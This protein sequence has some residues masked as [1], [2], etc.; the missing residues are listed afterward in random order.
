MTVA[1]L[2]SVSASADDIEVFTAGVHAN[3]RPNIM[4]VL[5]FSGSMNEGV[6]SSTKSR[7]EILESALTQVIDLNRDRINAGVSSFRWASTGIQWPV[8]DPNEYANAYDPAIPESDSLRVKDIISNIVEHQNPGSSTNTVSALVEAAAYFRGDAVAHGGINPDDT[9]LFKPHHWNTTLERYAGG[10]DFAANPITYTP[11]NAY[12]SGLAGTGKGYCRDYSGTG[13]TNHCAG[14]APLTCTTVPPRSGT[15]SE[16][17]NPW[18][19]DGYENC[20][21]PHPDTWQGATYNSPIENECQANF[22]VLISDGQPTS[23]WSYPGLESVLGHST[24]SCEDLSSS[25]F[26]DSGT[27][28]GNCGPE[29]VGQLHNNNQ[30]SGV[31]NSNV[32]TYTI[33]FNIDGDGSRYLDRLAEAGGGDFFNAQTP[34]DLGDA[35]DKSLNEILGGSANFAELS[36]DIDKAT[37]SNDNRVFFPLFEPSLRP[38]WEGNLKGY[39]IDHEGIKDVNNTLATIDD[40]TGT[41]FNDA[42]QSFWSSSADGD[43]VTLG[44]AS[45]KL[46]LATRNLFTFTSSAIAAGGS[47]LD[48][49]GDLHRLESTN[50]DIS[51]TMLGAADDTERTELLDWIQTQRMGDPLHSKITTVNY[52]GQSVVYLMT[53][54]GFLHAIDATTPTDPS[55]TDT[56]GGEELFAFMP[57]ELL[58]N[59]KALKNNTI[60]DPHVY[61][62]DGGMTRLHEDTNNNGIVDNSETVTLVFGQRRGGN[63][64]YALDVTDPTDPVYKWKIQGGVAPFD[65]QAQ[66]WSRMSLVRVK[67][68]T[69]SKKVLVFG[70]GYD[71]A[72]DGEATRKNA[73]GNSVYM[74][75]QDGSLIW[76]ASHGKMTYS[77]PSDPTII[78]SDNDGYA[79]RLYIGDTGGQLWRIDFDDVDTSSQFIVNP[80]ADLGETQYQPFFYPPSVALKDD[81]ATPYISLSI[82]SGN[83]TNPL[84]GST[85]NRLFSVHDTDVGKGAPAT[86]SGML[87]IGDLYDATAN[88]ISSSDTTTASNA[89]TELKSKRGWY[90]SLE[91]GE[92]VLSSVVTFEGKILAT[93]FSPFNGSASPAGLCTV[94]ETTG[95]YYALNL[96]DATPA[97]DLFSDDPDDNPTGG[98]TTN[99]RSKIISSRGIPSA[100]VIVF[101][102]G[103]ASVQIVVDKQ[104]VNDIVQTLEGVWWYP[105]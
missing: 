74:I 83:R 94:P 33:G 9:G 14:K 15:N 23:G 91:A 102:E 39:Y 22:I 55:V 104:T 27:N 66:S 81:I 50:T 19:S 18:S 92:K 67:S 60:G 30:I 65:K 6:P 4:F 87:K 35:L 40:G 11:A 86:G 72:I 32:S 56:S 89:A 51:A 85:Q 10:S 105:R 76:S 90:I 79:D 103:S 3:S 62:L 8:S 12:I 41:R 71:D 43:N 46:P 57:P 64:Y 20:N 24:S 100:P 69:S 16:T 80:L 70:A 95:R 26:T 52:P 37:F 98:L 25:I 45:E 13:G 5:D 68:G 31:E 61:G 84:D 93:T 77:I 82:G 96:A 63:A 17:G 53:N 1:L 21:Y 59:L 34:E 44:G 48:V 73:S 75:N 78:D 2:I 88:N 58:T 49:T 97:S 54:Q 99:D 38:G 47:A 28:K 29:V 42:A 7:A 36:I 101:P